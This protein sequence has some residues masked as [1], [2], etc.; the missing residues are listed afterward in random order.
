M[1]P[2]NFLLFHQAQSRHVQN[3]SLFSV[4]IGTTRQR[5]QRVTTLATGDEL[6][7]R[8]NRG[9]LEMKTACHW[10]ALLLGT[11][12]V[13]L[14]LLCGVGV[15]IAADKLHQLNEG[16]YKS[17]DNS[18]IAAEERSARV[19]R[20]LEELKFTAR[21]IDQGV[22]NWTKAEVG[23]RIGSKLNLEQKF[24]KAN[25]VLGS[26]DHFLELSESSVTLVQLAL[27]FARSLGV[28]V[29]ADLAVRIQEEIAS[30]REQLASLTE[31]LEF[32]AEVIAVSEADPD[33]E[34]FE[35]VMKVTARL[36]ATVSSLDE[37]VNTVNA[38]LHT[39]HE[40]A[41]DTQTRIEAW[42]SLA[43]SAL[44]LMAV[45]MAVGQ[46]LLCY[47]GWNGLRRQSLDQ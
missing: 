29:Q 11:I 39:M 7:L 22:K 19:A 1:P 10:I 33:S 34:Q 32:A 2:T 12:G 3:A 27:H 24:E 47:V 25:V 30:S 13:A 4:R 6:E 8:F 46:C 31:R 37:R 38:Q 41:F 35:R 15:W 45:W 21:D 18:L 43:S 26:V 17:V 14:C 20:R 28:S 40:R 42:I 23:D 44:M 5:R 16:L 36:V 9:V